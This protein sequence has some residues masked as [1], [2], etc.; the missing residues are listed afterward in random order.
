MINKRE[1]EFLDTVADKS[2]TYIEHPRWFKLNSGTKYMPDFYCKDDD[3]YIEVAGTRQAYFAN[4]YKYEQFQKEYP[5]I[6]FNIIH[7]WK[8]P[9]H[10]SHSDP[11]SYVKIAERNGVTYAFVYKILKGKNKTS[12][13]PLALE[14]AAKTGRAPIDYVSLPIRDMALK[15][16]PDLGTVHTKKLTQAK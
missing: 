12:N 4:R 14:V 2:K 7:L 3:E 1:Q 6:K 15:V 9:P 8:R 13:I 10:K 16:Y 11:N 5:E